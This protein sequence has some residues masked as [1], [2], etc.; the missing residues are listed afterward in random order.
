MNQF[1]CFN[2]LI[3]S[4]YICVIIQRYVEFNSQNNSIF[5]HLP[6]IK[7]VQYCCAFLAWFFYFIHKVRGLTTGH[8]HIY[9]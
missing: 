2:F 7:P 9:V 4:I 1:V 5:I 3:S 8:K 6:D